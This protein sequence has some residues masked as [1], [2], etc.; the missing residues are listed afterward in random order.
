MGSMEKMIL[1]AFVVIFYVV[2]LALISWLF[3]LVW[4]F[5]IPT[6]FHWVSLTFWQAMACV[7]LLGF[8]GSRFKS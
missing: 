8:V 5:V 4:N 1:I 6:A 7:F 2:I 3:M